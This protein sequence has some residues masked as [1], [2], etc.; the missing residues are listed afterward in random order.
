MIGACEKNVLRLQ[1]MRINLLPTYVFT[2]LLLADPAGARA[3]GQEGTLADFTLEQLSDIVVTSVARQETRLGS[4]PAAVYV[5]TGADIARSGAT[6]LPEALRL[7]P[8]LQVARRDASG[9]AISARGFSTTLSNKMLV[10]IDGRSVYSPLFSG[11]F[12]E[13]QDVDLADVERIEVISGPG[14]TVW[15]ANAVNGVINIITRPAHET[16]GGLLQGAAGQHAHGGMVRYGGSMAGG[17][18]YRAYAKSTRQDDAFDQPGESNIGWRRSQAGFRF[19]TQGEEHALTVSGDA[20]E[21]RSGQWNQGDIVTSGGNLLGRYTAHLASG[22]EIKAQA[23]LDQTRLDQPLGR[24]RL[25]TFDAELQHVVRLGER[26][27]LAWGG[28]YRYSVDRVQNK[29]QLVFDPAERKLRWANL[30]AQDEIALA[31]SLRLTLGAKF[32][33]NSYTGMEALPSVR[34]AW[35]LSPE[36]ML[37]AAASRAVRAPSRIDREVTIA[38]PGRTAG[39]PWSHAGSSDFQSETARVLELGYRGQPSSVLSYSATLFYSDYDHLRT[40]EPG[41]GDGT[42]FENL[43]QGRARGIELW[44]SWQPMAAWRL[45]AGAVAQ[46]VEVCPKPGSHDLARRTF[47]VNDDPGSYWQVRSSHDL[48]G[49]LRADLMLRRVAELPHPVVPAYTELDARLAWNARRDLEVALSGRNL[50]HARHT[51][52]GDPRTRLVFAR[53]VLLSASMHF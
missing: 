1:N 7:A 47:L 3:A 24:Q 37:W 8:N 12:W 35:E 31:D 26:H 50:L 40:L 13:S 42:L 30:F 21:G 38:L 5:I 17:V 20:Y 22:G 9:Y 27:Q 28:G 53:S 14:G 44:G 15:G 34:V 51:E 41:N 6:T 25:D 45:S 33:H 43:G 18:S 19:D 2:G 36:H 52:F 23:Y 4:A 32:E 49:N 39:P 16:Q 48:P 29:G 46:D 10:L 11:V